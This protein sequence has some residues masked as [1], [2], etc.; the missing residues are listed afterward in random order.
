MTQFQSYFRIHL[1]VKAGGTHC[2]LQMWQCIRNTQS[3]AVCEAELFWMTF[4]DFV[5][6][7]QFSNLTAFISLSLWLWVGLG[8][9]GWWELSASLQPGTVRLSAWAGG[10]SHIPKIL[11]LPRRG[12]QC[13]S[14]QAPCSALTGTAFRL[15]S[16]RWLCRSSDNCNEH[17]APGRSAGLGQLLHGSLGSF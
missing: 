9:C 15:Q 10:K 1:A 12:Q 7:H 2:V 5:S 3:H 8:G 6:I 4:P 16:P 13:T 17:F 14:A 11:L